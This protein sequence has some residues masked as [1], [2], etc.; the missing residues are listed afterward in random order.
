MYSNIQSVLFNKHKYTLKQTEEWL[1]KSNPKIIPIK[2]VHETKNFYRYRIKIPDYEK[3]HYITF[4]LNNGI[5]FVL[6]YPNK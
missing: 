5:Y 1:K 6:G 3:N 4:P 2:N